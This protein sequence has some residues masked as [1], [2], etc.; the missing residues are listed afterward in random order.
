MRALTLTL[1][2][3]FTVSSRAFRM[4]APRTTACERG[5]VPD[6]TSISQRCGEPPMSFSGQANSSQTCSSR[7]WPN[8]KSSNLKG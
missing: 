2:I 1:I 5:P 6:Q 3:A 4:P 7:S 8:L